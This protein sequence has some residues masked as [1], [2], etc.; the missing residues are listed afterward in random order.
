MRIKELIYDSCDYAK[1]YYYT[2]KKPLSDKLAE[3]FDEFNCIEF[4]EIDSLQRQ[5][6]NISLKQIDFSYL[7]DESLIDSFIIYISRFVNKHI[8][9][10]DRLLIIV[11]AKEIERK[12]YPAV[13]FIRTLNKILCSNSI[14]NESNIDSHQ[15]AIYMPSLIFTMY[16]YFLKFYIDKSLSS[17][18][19]VY[20]SE[21][22]FN[23]GIGIEDSNN[24]KLDNKNSDKKEGNCNHNNYQ[25]DINYDSDRDDYED[26]KSITN[27]TSND[28]INKGSKINFDI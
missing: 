18:I 12:N 19:D 24:S 2:N 3:L 14:R 10:Y 9:S 28:I 15:I 8:K 22:S 5:V 6:F 23:E 13:E 20:K 16:L 27:T 25:N 26:F 1:Q 21:E 11:N 17:L 4:K 7:K